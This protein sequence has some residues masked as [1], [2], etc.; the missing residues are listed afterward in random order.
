M[1]GHA[2]V[3]SPFIKMKWDSVWRMGG[4]FANVCSKPASKVLRSSS[5]VETGM[6]VCACVCCVC[7]SQQY[8]TEF[9]YLPVCTMKR[10][11]SRYYFTFIWFVWVRTGS[12]G[13][14]QEH[15]SRRAQRSTEHRNFRNHSEAPRVCGISYGRCLHIFRHAHSHIPH[16][17]KVRALICLE[18]CSVHIADIP[19][20]NY[21][22]FPSE[23]R[24]ALMRPYITSE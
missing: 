9:N 13:M 15:S 4:R 1:I 14:E 2:G 8:P 20:L 12:G 16:T 22:D 7:V 3:D 6:P 5:S 10:T 19:I 21:F 17:H 23:G 11:N 18:P 24:R